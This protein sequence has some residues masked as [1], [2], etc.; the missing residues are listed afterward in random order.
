MNYLQEFHLIIDDLL[1]HIGFESKILLSH[2]HIIGLEVDDRFSI[3]FQ[4]IDDNSWTMFAN[5]G[6]SNLGQNGRYDEFIFCK[7]KMDVS[8]RLPIIAINEDN[9]LNCWLILP[10][11]GQDLPSLLDAFDTI[12]ATAE[13]IL[14][15]TEIIIQDAPPNN[16][17]AASKYV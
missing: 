7:Q 17:L 13:K 10:L 4:L 6:P 8:K 15:G 14:D 1:Q 5:L 16:L 2:H 9:H 11:H 12:V 3:Y